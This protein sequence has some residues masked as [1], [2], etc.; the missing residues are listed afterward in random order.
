MREKTTITVV[1]GERPVEIEITPMDAVRGE[2]WLLRAGAAI[3]GAIGVFQEGVATTPKQIMDALGAID[4]EKALPLW[5]ELIS[6][7]RIKGQ[8]SVL[9]MDT[10]AGK[11]D[12][13]ITIMKIKFESLKANFGFF[14]KEGGL[15]SLTGTRG[16]RSSKK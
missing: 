12:Y 7:C 1:D 15:S 2:R 6:C 9:N 8:E 4:I 11:F 14:T 3:G 5:D 13:P 10:L 16:S